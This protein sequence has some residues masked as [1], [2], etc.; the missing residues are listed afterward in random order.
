MPETGAVL[1][2]TAGRLDLHFGLVVMLI[3]SLRGT[4]LGAGDSGIAD[5]DRCIGPVAG[6]QCTCFIREP[7]DVPCRPVLAMALP[8]MIGSWT[9]RSRRLS[10]NL[11]Q[12]AGNAG[13]WMA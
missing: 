6:A 4:F 2:E 5:I 12:R 8:H 7:L 9:A 10:R 11:L 1:N 13:T 3:V